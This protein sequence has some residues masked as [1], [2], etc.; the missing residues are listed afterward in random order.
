[1]SRATDPSPDASP[2]R[3]SELSAIIARL[4]ALKIETEDLAKR[5]AYLA[6]QTACAFTSTEM[7][8]SLLMSA[9]QVRPSP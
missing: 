4:G 9:D 7:L 8:V 5:I 1:M 6:A 3:S 2:G